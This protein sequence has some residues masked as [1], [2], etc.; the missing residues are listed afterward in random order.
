MIEK[1]GTLEILAVTASFEDVQLTAAEEGC[2]F[3]H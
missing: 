2:H 1:T 3:K